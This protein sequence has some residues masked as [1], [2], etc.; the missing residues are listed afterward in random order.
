M[1]RPFLYELVFNYG[2]SSLIAGKWHLV[3]ELPQPYLCP[4]AAES[5]LPSKHY[6]QI[7]I[8]LLDPAVYD[9]NE[10][11]LNFRERQRHLF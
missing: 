2:V 5:L 10:G 6:C 8:P 4:R 3:L 7:S 11:A 1:P 9:S